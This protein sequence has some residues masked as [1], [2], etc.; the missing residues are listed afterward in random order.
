[1]RPSGQSRTGAAPTLRP[2][3][4]IHLL[5]PD[6]SVTLLLVD[7]EIPTGVRIDRIGLPYR[8]LRTK[9]GAR[10]ALPYDIRAVVDAVLVDKNV[11]GLR[12]ALD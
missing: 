11:V 2:C 12:V 5:L 3:P 1:M 7:V 10:I 8:L 4:Y 6:Q 9:S